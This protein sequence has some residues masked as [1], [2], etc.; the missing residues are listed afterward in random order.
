M[1]KFG[2]LVLL[3]AEQSICS[4]GAVVRQASNLRA[5]SSS[6]TFSQSIWNNTFTNFIQNE[7]DMPK[8]EP[9]KV[10]KWAYVL[11]A[12]CF[13]I[14]GCDR[15]YMGQVLLGCLKCLTG[16]GFFIWH[17]IDYFTA[18]ISALTHAKEINTMGYHAQF[19]EK[20]I[21]T[22]FYVCIGLFVWD[23]VQSVGRVQAAKAQAAMQQEQMEKLTKA[24]GQEQ[25]VPRRHQSLAYVPTMFTKGLRKAGI[26]TETPTMPELIAAFDKMDKDGDGQLDHEEIK[27]GLKAMGASDETVDEMI[28]SADTDGD[29]K[30]SKD[31]FLV[32][33]SKKE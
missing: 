32:A 24:T 12:M 20:T 29:G 19:Q 7:L 27:E 28:K 16:G 10:N 31:E 26:V 6:L 9:K 4:S 5:Q 1:A 30:I 14:C 22:A 2:I 13:G 18:V 3:L 21:A 11:L 15:C 17:I 33:L 23:V 8:A 25:D